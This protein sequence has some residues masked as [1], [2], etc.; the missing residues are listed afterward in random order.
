[1]TTWIVVSMMVLSAAP[2]WAQ[3]QEEE[4][5]QRVKAA[6]QAAEINIA[7][8]PGECGRAEIT[9]RVGWG[10]RGKGWGLIVKTGS[11]NGCGP[12]H[13]PFFSSSVATMSR[14]GTSPFLAKSACSPAAR[15][16]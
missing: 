5:V 14:Y 6:V 11:Q 15:M 16:G 3:S 9:H 7:H 4:Y 8:G 1:M 13:Q 2:V 12:D 10:L